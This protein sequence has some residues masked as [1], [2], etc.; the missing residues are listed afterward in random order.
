MGACE[1]S[2]WAVFLG[3]LFTFSLLLCMAQAD[4]HSYTLVLQETE[5]ERLCENKSILVANGSFP[6][7]TVWTHRGDTVVVTVVNKGNYGVTIHWHGARQMYNPWHDGP[8]YVTQ[9]PIQPQQNFTQTIVLDKEEGTLWWH[10]HNDWTR[11]ST[12]ILGEWYGKNLTEMVINATRTGGDVDTS[13]AYTIN[14]QPGDFYQCSKEPTY[15]MAVDPNKTYLL[16]IISAIM[17][18]EM[19]FGI[20]N[21]TLTL[22]GMDGAY[23]E[24]VNTSYIMIA[25]GQ[26]MDVLVTTDQKPSH[27]YVLGIPFVD[28]QAP[29]DT[30]TPSAI[31]HYSGRYEPPAYPNS[32]ILPGLTERNSAESFMRLLKSLVDDKHPIKVPLNITKRLYLTVSVNNVECAQGDTCEGPHGNRHSASL[33]NISWTVPNIDILQAYYRKLP[34]IYYTD[35]PDQPPRYFDFA[36]DVG[37]NVTYPVV[38]RTVVKPIE[39]G[40]EVELIF[41]GTNIPAAENHPMHLHGY[42]FYLVGFGRG[43][44][45]LNMSIPTYNLTHPPK[46]NTVALPKNGWATI[47]FK[48]NNPGVWFMHCHLEC[49]ASWGMAMAFLLRKRACATCPRICPLVRD[50]CDEIDGASSSP[51]SAPVTVIDSAELVS[52]SESCWFVGG[53]TH[54][55]QLVV[56]SSSS[57]GYGGLN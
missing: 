11:A 41:Q 50:H 51:L 12:I 31:L 46:I 43:N 27:Y 42:S 6:G 54:L 53:Q 22:V 25:P 45:S 17:N 56:V 29:S 35:F 10:A 5:F 13:V 15:R 4:V 7:P 8:A 14:G 21:H 57:S 44:F 37:D 1:K 23:L 32:I 9:C 55:P 48:A 28:T 34:G 26:T 39:Y 3:F 2:S 19:F 47:R 36:G 52:S 16:R 30:T 38:G 24:Q 40:S 49:H 20:A 18:E 33:N